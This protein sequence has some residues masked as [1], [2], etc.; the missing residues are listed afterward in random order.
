MTSSSPSAQRGERAPLFYVQLH[1]CQSGVEIVRPLYVELCFEGYIECYADDVE[2]VAAAVGIEF[3]DRCSLFEPQQV[4]LEES[5]NDSGKKKKR[6]FLAPRVLLYAPQYCADLI[7]KPGQLFSNGVQPELELQTFKYCFADSLLQG[8]DFGTFSVSRHLARVSI[9]LKRLAQRLEDQAVRAD[10]HLDKEIVF[11]FDHNPIISNDDEGIV[12]VS[13]HKITLNRLSDAT[14]VCQTLLNGTKARRTKHP[15]EELDKIIAF[16]NDDNKRDEVVLPDYLAG[17]FFTPTDT[18]DYREECCPPERHASVAEFLRERNDIPYRYFEGCLRHDKSANFREPEKRMRC[19]AVYMAFFYARRQADF[20]VLEALL[21]ASLCLEGVDVA[22]FLREPHLHVRVLPRFLCTFTFASHY[23][24]DEDGDQWMPLRAHPDPELASGDCEDHALEVCLLYFDL[25]NASRSEKQGEDTLLTDAVCALK[26]MAELYCPFIVDC[27]AKPDSQKSQRSLHNYVHLQRW[28]VV[29]ELLEDQC[30]KNQKEILRRHCDEQLCRVTEEELPHYP[31]VLFIEATHSMS[32]SRSFD[33]YYMERADRDTLIME[34][35][36]PFLFMSKRGST[37]VYETLL[38]SYAPILYDLLQISFMTFNVRQPDGG[39][40]LFHG[41]RSDLR[42]TG[43]CGIAFEKWTKATPSK[44]VNDTAAPFALVPEYDTSVAHNAA[45]LRAMFAPMPRLEASPTEVER[46]CA[47][48]IG[49]QAQSDTHQ[50]MRCLLKE[51]DV[52]ALSERA[53]RIASISEA[54]T[55][56]SVR[57]FPLTVR[58]VTIGI[59][60]K[61]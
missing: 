7:Q 53:H 15:V 61:H 3:K 10:K 44:G 37:E 2:L 43:C 12:S 60:D 9:P 39:V 17:V 57:G 5:S 56:F 52:D 8:A 13:I 16:T 34:T 59:P 55:L 28:D 54:F 22:T 20:E 14:S 35:D 24:N 29:R 25:I 51:K 6:A 49:Q 11:K 18:E 26:Q 45:W 30:E 33:E 40:K 47:V 38:F 36:I 4:Y 41:K 1:D 42:A 32:A 58:I 50:F 19:W 48:S 23:T 21:A 31:R 27:V 46:I